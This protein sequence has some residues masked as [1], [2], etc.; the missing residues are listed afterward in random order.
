ML[1]R[2]M[3]LLVLAMVALLGFTALAVDGSMVYSDRRFAQSGS[4]ASS[5]AGGAEAADVIDGPT[6]SGPRAPAV[7]G[8]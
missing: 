7:S 1:L 8:T 3:G 5:L 4:D 2:V 6:T